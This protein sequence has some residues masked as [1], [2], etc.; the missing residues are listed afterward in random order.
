[1]CDACSQIPCIQM[2]C[3]HG[4]VFINTDPEDPFQKTCTKND[5]EDRYAVTFHDNK[6]EVITSWKR[7]QHYLF[8]A[9]KE[10]TFR[11]PVEQ[12][13]KDS[14]HF[15]GQFALM[16]YFADPADFK[17]V[18]DG[19]LKGKVMMIDE[20]DNETAEGK[21]VDVQYKP[22]EFCV[23]KTEVESEENSTNLEFQTFVCKFPSETKTSDEKCEALMIKV[24]SSTLI[25]SIVFLLLTLIIYMIEPSLQKQYLFCR[26]TVA[27]ILNLTAAFIIVV[28]VELSKDPDKLHLGGNDGTTLSDLGKYKD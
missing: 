16:E 26:I 19:S 24:K 5:D 8:V 6:G 10:E 17:I 13:S 28:L 3:P 15:D 1:M 12:M 20:N 18:M 9:P 22:Q 4:E 25:I 21:I 2:C 11:C 14:R 27:L 7:N 23:V